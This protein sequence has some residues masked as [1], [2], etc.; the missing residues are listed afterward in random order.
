MLFTSAVSAVAM[1][2]V[3]E[4]TKKTALYFTGGV[5][6]GVVAYKV[7]TVAYSEYLKHKN[8]SDSKVEET[9]ESVKEEVVNETEAEAKA[10]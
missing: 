1:H 9:T 4:G 10:S 8:K 7:G 6:A 5:V 3:S 2:A